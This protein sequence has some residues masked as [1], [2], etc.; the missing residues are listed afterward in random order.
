MTETKTKDSFGLN[1]EEMTKVGLQFGRKTS[2][3]HSK[4]RPYLAGSKNTISIIDLEKSKDCLAKAL[5]FIKTSKVQG[6][7]ILIIGTKPH[8][9][10]IV[11]EAAL[12]MKLPFVVERWLGGAFTNFAVILKRMEYFKDLQKKK[13]EGGLEKYTKKE[14]AE[15]SKELQRLEIKFG[16]MK[17]LIALPDIILVLS[18]GEDS[19]A[20]K[21]AKEKNIKIVGLLNTDCNPLSIDYPIPANN[22]AVSS[23]KY[24]L[25]KIKEAIKQ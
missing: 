12:E 17:D 4:M 2:K 13:A 20:I 10:D 15:F 6:K 3:C 8:L 25:E 11:R 19:L 7:T 1:I 22:D 9:K 16:G 21:E 18:P 24:I 5:D 14:Q 23:V